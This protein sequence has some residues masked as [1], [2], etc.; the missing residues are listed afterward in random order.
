[1][2]TF[3]PY[4]DVRESIQSL[5]R[6]RLFAMC[7]ESRQILCANVA[8]RYGVKWGWQNHAA[9]RMWEGFDNALAYYMNSAIVEWRGRGYKYSRSRIPIHGKIIFPTWFGRSYFHAAHRSNLLRKDPEFYG[10]YG[11]KEPLDLEYCWG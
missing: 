10:R 1:M 9:A 6:K 2:Q 4:P 3:L 7:R 5:D 8:K 11:W